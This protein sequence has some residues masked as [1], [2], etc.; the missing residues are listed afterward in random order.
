MAEKSKYYETLCNNHN[1]VIFMLKQF[2]KTGDISLIN[3]SIDYVR[4]C[5][6]QGQH[7]ERR[8]CQYRSA[9]ESLGFQRVGGKFDN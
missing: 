4:H 2:K 9:L 1:Q 3:E 8:L 7:M 5:K 6:K